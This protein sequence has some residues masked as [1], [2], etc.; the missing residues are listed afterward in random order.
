MSTLTFNDISDVTGPQTALGGW[1]L[2]AENRTGARNLRVPMVRLPSASLA[3]SLELIHVLRSCED[4]A[5]LGRRTAWQQI[6]NAAVG[7]LELPSASSVRVWITGSKVR[8][9]GVPEMLGHI[10][11]SL[12]LS[13]TELA[14]ILLVERATVYNWREGSPVRATNQD[15]IKQIYQIADAW[16]NRYE[17]PVGREAYTTSGAGTELLALLR[18]PELAQSSIEAQLEAV[19]RTS[20]ARRSTTVRRESIAD[21]ARRLGIPPVPEEV[22]AD[23]LYFLDH[24]ER[25]RS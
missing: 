24:R 18:T 14:S 4:M 11:H 17:R 16:W 1:A 9:P 5:E 23:S 19:A 2:A 10:R 22:R 12:S 7:E 3:P 15:R 25:N 21:R 6:L 8:A 13:T 20:D